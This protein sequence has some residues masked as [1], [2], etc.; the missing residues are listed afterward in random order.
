[1]VKSGKWLVFMGLGILVTSLLVY[2]VTYSIKN[3]IGL[4]SSDTLAMAQLVLSLLLLPTVLVGF[5]ITVQAFRES[6]EL[7]DLDLVLKTNSGIY[8][9]NLKFSSSSIMQRRKE[10]EGRSR[11]SELPIALAVINMGNAIA[12][13][14]AISITIQFDATP[15]ARYL[16]WT[17][18][19]KTGGEHWQR[20]FAEL[21]TSK[22]FQTMF[23]SNGTLAAYPK[24]PLNI[25]E[26]NTGWFLVENSPTKDYYISYTIVTDR[27]FKKQGALKVTFQGTT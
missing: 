14:Y 8:Q 1:M 22:R 17:Q 27:G 23:M 5:Y 4:N 11:E 6:Q 20:N 7:P 21:E 26:M 12:V 10:S 9:N 16:D 2:I 13:W 25:C 18:F 19:Y 3:L 15:Q 24:M